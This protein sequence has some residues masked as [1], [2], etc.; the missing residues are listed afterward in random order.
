[1]RIPGETGNFHLTG[2]ARTAMVLV[3]G[4][5]EVIGFI[6]RGSDAPDLRAGDAPAVRAKPSGARRLAAAAT[7]VEPQAPA[8]EAPMKLRPAEGWRVRV[9]RFL[10]EPDRRPWPDPDRRREPSFDD[11]ILHGPRWH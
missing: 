10:S 1:G 9:R 5:A 4:Y 2:Y 11:W 8:P 6:P 3:T 7:G